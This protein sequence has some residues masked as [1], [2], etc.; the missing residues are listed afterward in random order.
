MMTQ[1]SFNCTF[2]FQITVPGEDMHGKAG[3]DLQYTK[4]TDK[5][6]QLQNLKNACTVYEN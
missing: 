5:S 3:T 1:D 2:K 6:L 4:I